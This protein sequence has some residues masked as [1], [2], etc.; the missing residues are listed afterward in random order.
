MTR[1]SG[2]GSC[3]QVRLD[4]YW[5]VY[6]TRSSERTVGPKDDMTTWKQA[7]CT[8]AEQAKEIWRWVLDRLTR[9]TVNRPHWLWNLIY[10][11]SMY[12]GAP[13]GVVV[14][15]WLNRK[16]NFVCHAGHMPLLN[17]SSQR[18]VQIKQL[19]GSI[20]HEIKCAKE[21]LEFNKKAL[22]KSMRHIR[23]T[24]NAMN[25][26]CSKINGFIEQFIRRSQLKKTERWLQSS[27]VF[28]VIST[29]YISSSHSIQPVLEGRTHL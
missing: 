7:P 16:R 2:L 19:R 17:S 11:A 18:H 1:Q 10:S 22:G 24:S 4:S 14:R 25:V 9:R 28:T 21:Y 3:W 29:C 8:T 15:W 26:D 5:H 23:H 12:S 13:T 6:I 27:L 20:T